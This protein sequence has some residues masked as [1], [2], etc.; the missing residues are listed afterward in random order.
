MNLSETIKS[1]RALFIQQKKN[2]AEIIVD[3][4]TANRYAV[5]DEQK[6]I[7]GMIA[8][9][10]KGF[11]HIL[12]RWFF[13][14]HRGFE[15]TAVNIDGSIVLTLARKF[16]FFFS[17]LNVT[18]GHQP[19]GSV[20]RRFGIIYKK[21]DLR[22]TTGQTFATI[23]S[24]IWRL[25]TFPILD[26]RGLV[27]GAEVSKK[28]GGALKEVFTDADTFRVDFGAGGF[29]AQQRALIFAAAISIDFDFFEKNQ[30]V[31]GITSMFD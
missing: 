9:N 20:N 1:Q 7:V 27:Q 6:N 13:R 3:F 26:N 19:I 29:T 4:E 16:F 23:K 30:G 31:G 8:E 14:S 15:A 11:M 24:P 5:M 12:K 2:W 10:G 21:Y 25:W 17:D 22:D 18:Y 28:W